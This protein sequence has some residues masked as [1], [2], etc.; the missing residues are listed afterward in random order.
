MHLVHL[1]RLGTSKND[2]SSPG[3]K[4]DKK[5]F[6]RSKNISKAV[7]RLSKEETELD[8]APIGHI[9]K[10]AFHN[11]VRQ[12]WM[13]PSITGA[14]IKHGSCRW[15]SVLPRWLN[16]ARNAKHWNHEDVELSEG[17]RLKQTYGRR[18]QYSKGLTMILNG[19]TIL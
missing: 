6:K 8:E 5:S 13:L 3:E 16:F 19:M 7:D 18:S 1:M 15:C 12:I 2:D 10:G 11:L 9:R 17:L 4:D 14:D